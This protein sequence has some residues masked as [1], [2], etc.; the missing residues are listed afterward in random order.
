MKKFSF[1][2]ICLFPFLEILES[3]VFSW[4]TSSVSLSLNSVETTVSGNK[5]ITTFQ[6]YAPEAHNYKIEFWLMGVKHLDGSYS[7]YDLR[8]DNGTVSDQ[9]V[10]DC[11]DWCLYSPENSSALYL[12]QGIHSISL[13][14]SLNDVPNAESV[15][16]T[17]SN[18]W[19]VSSGGHTLTAI[20][21]YQSLKNHVLQINQIIVDSL[22]S[23][24]R[25][26]DCFPYEHNSASPP[27]YYTAELN[28]TVF[29]TFYR[30]EYYT[31]GQTITYETD[32]IN[33]VDHVL[34]VF[35]PSN[36]GSCSWSAASENG[37]ATL[38]VTIPQTGFYYV[39]V[40]TDS[41]E[42]WGTC[43][44]TINNDR[45]FEGIPVGCSRTE[46]SLPSA[47]GEEFS[48]FALSK[49]GNPS[50]MLIDDGDVVAYNDDFPYDA[51]LSD[52]DWGKNARIDGPLSE[53]QWLLSI[54]PKSLSAYSY[55]VYTGCRKTDLECFS[56]F[57][58]LD[59]IKSSEVSG[60]YNCISW[61]VGEWMVGLW[62]NN[63]NGV[64]SSPI[65]Y[66]DV[67]DSIFTAYN[68]IETESENPADIDLWK[69]YNDN[70]GMIEC[71]H[72]SIR[73]KRGQYA[74]GYDWESKLGANVRVFHPRYALEGDE[75]GEVFAHYYRN[76]ISTISD[77]IQIMP[78]FLNISLTQ[79]EFERIEQGVSQMKGELL[80]QFDEMYTECQ[81]NGAF[82][83]SVCIDSFEEVKPYSQLLALCKNYPELHYL[84]YQ[85]VCKRE[86]LA[87]K[88]LVDIAKAADK[89]MLD[90]IM[91]QVEEKRLSMQTSEQKVLRTVQSDALALVKA[92][93]SKENQYAPFVLTEENI[94]NSQ[95]EMAKISVKERQLT[96]EFDLPTD[97]FVSVMLG[98][99]NGTMISDVVSLHRMSAGKQ[100][101]SAVVSE[102]GIYTV[103][104]AINGSIYKKKVKIQ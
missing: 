38:S 1:L 40:R 11:G 97:A 72:A 91:S 9:V 79:E 93:L 87:I 102:S 24:Y 76:T 88:L 56:N 26:I 55:D 48:C 46:I 20:A 32:V 54:N 89:Q 12:T 5:T 14:G 58:N 98:N 96:I 29:Y 41:N 44:L 73:S 39:L 57:K 4:T 30:K 36:P 21:N 19:P 34:N 90:E 27:F 31:I 75:Y 18:M 77:S 15:Y 25:K 104:I 85:K 8:V 13:E 92:L 100:Q 71:T 3:R 62:L 61:A 95:T 52:Y 70:T 10:T 81:K 67:L 16:G 51:T 59:I 78:D 47:Y 42:E 74:A 45:R 7:S 23:V 64:T 103:G 35:N 49:T 66:K 94:S 33:G 2:F 6:V 101:I 53:D 84:I 43:N 80:Y 69:R 22:T 82:R 28:K 65:K 99:L 83:V 37:H 63:Y 17:Y 60:Y 50:V 86:I 68:Y